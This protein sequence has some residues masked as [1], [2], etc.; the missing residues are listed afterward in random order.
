MFGD[1]RRA[2][3]NHHELLL[4]VGVGVWEP[5]VS[6][7]G[8]ELCPFADHCRGVMFDHLR[9][10]CGAVQCLGVH[11]RQCVQLRRRGAGERRLVHIP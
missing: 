5:R 7:H 4:L 8:R 1:H 9:R 6:P 3:R 11:G 2:G 10:I